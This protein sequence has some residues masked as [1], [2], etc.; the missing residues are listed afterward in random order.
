MNSSCSTTSTTSASAD[1]ISLF[2]LIAKQVT[3][4]YTELPAGA[5]RLDDHT[6]GD[7]QAAWLRRSLECDGETMLA[8]SPDSQ[9]VCSRLREAAGAPFLPGAADGGGKQ[10]KHHPQPGSAPSDGEAASANAGFPST[11]GGLLSLLGPDLVSLPS[12]EAILRL[13]QND[14]AAVVVLKD[15]VQVLVSD[16]G[17]SGGGGGGVAGATSASAAAAPVALHQRVVW[18]E[19]EAV[20]GCGWGRVQGGSKI[21]VASV[22]VAAVH[23]VYG[24]S[25]EFADVLCTAP[26]AEPANQKGY[27]R[28]VRICHYSRVFDLFAYDGGKYKRLFGIAGED[29]ERQKNDLDET[30]T[31]NANRIPA[32]ATVRKGKIETKVELL[33]FLRNGRPGKQTSLL[34][35]LL[36]DGR[37]LNCSAFAYPE[38]IEAALRL[39]FGDSFFA[40][41]LS[42]GRADVADV[43]LEV[44]VSSFDFQETGQP[45]IQP[46]SA[47]GQLQTHERLFAYSPLV[48]LLTLAVGRVVNPQGNRLPSI[49]TRLGGSVADLLQ[50]APELLRKYNYGDGRSV[51]GHVGPSGGGAAASADGDSWC[52]PWPM[53]SPSESSYTKAVAEPKRSQTS[54]QL[55]DWLSALVVEICYDCLT[56][57]R[58]GTLSF[59]TDEVRSC[60]RKCFAYLHSDWCRVCLSKLEAAKRGR[61]FL[62][63]QV[64]PQGRAEQEQLQQEPQQ[65]Q[66]L[67]HM[68]PYAYKHQT[69]HAGPPPVLLAA[70]PPAAAATAPVVP[71]GVNSIASSSV[72][73]G[74]TDNSQHAAFGGNNM[75]FFTAGGGGIFNRD[76][77]KMDGDRLLDAHQSAE[78]VAKYFF[79]K[80]YFEKNITP[81]LFALIAKAYYNTSIN[82]SARS[83]PASIDLGKKGSQVF[84]AIFHELFHEFRFFPKYPNRELKLAARVVGQFLFHD[85]I[86]PKQLG[87]ALNSV[88]ESVRQ[89]GSKMFKYGILVLEQMLTRISLWPRFCELLVSQEGL[90]EQYPGYVQYL[91]SIVQEMPAHVRRMNVIDTI[92]QS[93]LAIPLPFIHEDLVA[94]L[95]NGGAPLAA[96]TML[97][98][99][100][101]EMGGS[102]H[103]V[104]V[105]P[106]SLL[107]ALW[108]DREMLTRLQNAV[109]ATPAPAVGGPGGTSA[110]A[111]PTTSGGAAV[112]ATGAAGAV[113]VSECQQHGERESERSDT[114][115]KNTEPV[116]VGTGLEAAGGSPPAQTQTRAEPTAPATISAAQEQNP[117]YPSGGPQ[118]GS[119][120]AVVTSATASSSTS[121]DAAAAGGGHAASGP[122]VFGGSERS[123]VDQI[124]AGL[125]VDGAHDWFREK[126]QEVFKVL[127]DLCTTGEQREQQSAVFTSSAAGPSSTAPASCVATSGTKPGAGSTESPSKSAPPTAAQARKRHASLVEQTQILREQL[128]R[129]EVVEKETTTRE[130]MLLVDQDHATTASKDLHISSSSSSVQLN[131]QWLALFV[132]KG[133]AA[134][135][136]PT[137]QEVFLTFLQELN[138]P[139]LTDAIVVATYDCLKLCLQQ[140]ELAVQFTGHR[141]VLKNLGYW[142][143]QLTIARNKPLKSRQLDL[144]NLL[145]DAF[146]AGTL[147]AVLPLVCKILEGVA[148]SKVF[149]LP[150]PWTQAVLC[151]LAEIHGVEDLRANLVFEIEVLCRN[152]D[153]KLADLKQKN[154]RSLQGRKPRNMNDLSQSARQK[155]KKQLLVTSTTASR[156]S[157]NSPSSRHV[158]YLSDM[159]VKRVPPFRHAV[160]AGVDA[161]I[162][163]V[164]AVIMER[165]VTISCLTTKETVS[166]DFA[167]EPDENVLKKAAQL[168]V[169]SVAG[170]L[171][172]VT[173]KEQLCRA[174]VQQLSAALLGG[175][176]ESQYHVFTTVVHGLA[177]E[178]L[179]LACSLVEKAVV[180]RALK[181][182]ERYMDFMNINAALIDASAAGGGG[183]TT[184][185]GG[186]GTTSSTNSSRLGGSIGGRLGGLAAGTHHGG[187]GGTTAGSTPAVSSLSLAQQQMIMRNGG[188]ADGRAQLGRAAPGR[189]NLNQAGAAGPS[190]P[191]RTMLAAASGSGASSL[192][193]TSADARREVAE[194]VVDEQKHQ[195]HN[196]NIGGAMVGAPSG[197]QYGGACGNFDQAYSAAAVSLSASV[198]THQIHGGGAMASSSAAGATNQVIP[199][200]TRSTHSPEKMATQGSGSNRREART[201]LGVIGSGNKM[202]DPQDKSQNFSARASATGPKTDDRG[203]VASYSYYEFHFF[204]SMGP[205]LHATVVAIPDLHSYANE[206]L[207][208]L[209]IGH[210]IFR[211]L[212]LLKKNNRSGHVAALYDI[213]V[214]Q[215]VDM[216]RYV[217]DEASAIVELPATCAFGKKL[218]EERQ[219]VQR[220]YFQIVLNLL[221]DM[222]RSGDATL[223]KIRWQALVA[224]S[225]FFFHTSP[226]RLPEFAFAWLELVSHKYFLPAMLNYRGQKGWLGFHRL[227]VAL[228]KFL[229]PFLALP[230]PFPESARTLYK[231]TLRVLLVLS[232]DY[233]EFL[234][235]YNFSLLQ[236]I[237]APCL[238]LRN[239]LLSAFPKRM[240]LPDP[241]LPTL[242]IHNL[243]EIQTQPRIL[244]HFSGMLGNA[245][246]SELDAY[247][248]GGGQ[249]TGVKDGTNPR[250]QEHAACD[251]QGVPEH[252]DELLNAIHERLLLSSRQ[253]LKCGTKHRCNPALLDV[254]VLYVGLHL[255]SS[256]EPLSD[257]QLGGTSTATKSGSLNG[258]TEPGAGA[259]A[260]CRRPPNS[261]S[262][263]LQFFFC[264]TRRVDDEA[265]Y[266]LFSLLANQ[267]RFPNAHTYC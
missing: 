9:H 24:G 54:R 144:K 180:D 46:L 228:L 78:T 177:R 128:R 3:D 200:G 53:T 40:A 255:G 117:T 71:Y 123:S 235:D 172:V 140:V 215:M 45:T 23:A 193:P 246:K 266:V 56:M 79:H 199:A 63:P 166:K 132:L 58:S 83:D 203:L 155:Q 189:G 187:S 36:G 75:L 242:K 51:G 219:Y 194:P 161:A 68:I 204:D 212:K 102:E 126:A 238:Q 202:N 185:R 114:S 130:K 236:H 31:A 97:R 244:C 225:S 148:A 129:L 260:T 42:D 34:Q 90:R 131:Y 239:V 48:F 44:L 205:M 47:E 218:E 112:A 168:M 111:A 28:F 11:A 160:P 154:E 95:E 191:N 81:E 14:A 19:F 21:D 5:G 99:A 138:E 18:S 108:R 43:V 16:C 80:L 195:Q 253:M 181:E 17:A 22:F 245:L 33:P 13:C 57:S 169:S 50:Q 76:T 92:P 32:P 38:A 15:V 178:N 221:G 263:V 139:K 119:G 67:P 207:I 159:L 222:V 65:Q 241:F 231:G 82:T 37:R 107:Q 234:A 259:S 217:H 267:L 171:A 84:D 91:Q 86:P 145:F 127:S 77:E 20:T 94:G 176:A 7:A 229:K 183:A 167:M 165:S 4:S 59:P 188:N 113:V 208:G 124:L 232:H 137:A 206:Q 35:Y 158:H 164:I 25:I 223:E 60:L 106:S 211:R 162:R 29:T 163:E 257:L 258:T 150:N 143:G 116:A 135:S 237:P 133:H 147:T 73:V 240:R 30:P 247:L 103:E 105:D 89:P 61:P 151:L 146:A 156:G 157:Y 214:K 12:M 74:R 41:M 52:G 210:R 201:P 192:S 249:E 261:P 142:L 197:P 220:V 122:L 227:L 196:I 39:P 109:A 64:L 136:S 173:C 198:Y 265:Q 134:N 72:A 251:P 175:S 254:V 224:F 182:V 115:Q 252:D 120:A 49:L 118:S 243:A 248:A 141:M 179:P 6:A 69:N 264:L 174:L 87:I 230:L 250:R 70:P 190:S 186:A 121:A 55:A 1:D 104:L 98:G 213:R 10:T 27:E 2:R 256:L 216:L 85:L 96:T 262:R 149:R 100:P 125:K 26:L 110:S 66:Q 233:P 8:G 101:G 153:I 62:P 88:V 209:Y 152:L 170:S 93:V 184:G 226:L